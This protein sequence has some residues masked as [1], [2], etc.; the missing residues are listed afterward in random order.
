MGV[1]IG[2]VVTFG[3]I[4]G[5]YM[6]MGGKLAV[7]MQPFELVIIGGAGVGGLIVAN[8][9]KVIKDVG[10]SLV[11][12]IKDTAPKESDYLELLDLLYRLL[13]DLKSKPKAEIERAIDEPA[14]G[15]LFAGA[16]GVLAK[17]E[18]T[19]FICDYARLILVGSARA[20]E[21]EALMDEEIETLRHDRMKAQ[22]ALQSMADAFPAIGIVAAVLG[23][24]KAMGA[25]DQSPEILGALIGAALVGTFLGVFLSYSI[26]GPLAELVKVTRGKQLRPYTIVKQSLIAHLNGS[27]PQVSIEHGRK[28][29]PLASRPSLADVERRTLEG[30]DAGATAAAA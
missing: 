27:V 21:I 25:I 9:M 22:H 19:A 28:T 6:A 10:R 7:L 14:E 17:P 26:V 11:E 12:A 1:L 29:I 16:P 3:S 20:H 24:I 4:L 5:G 30:G 18:L 15:E 23:V 8:P 2:L 13:T